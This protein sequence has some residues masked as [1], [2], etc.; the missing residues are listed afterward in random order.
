MKHLFLTFFACMALTA[1]AAPD[2][3]FHIYL[4]FGQSNMEGNARPEAQDY[5]GVS[6]RFQ[7]L[8]AVDFPKYGTKQGEWRTA[9]PPLARPETGLTPVDYFGRT[10]VANTPDDVRIG[11]VVV[12]VGGCKIALFDKRGCRDYVKREAPDWMQGP[13]RAYG[14]NPY[15]RLLTLARQA[16]Q[17]GVIK[18][19]LLHQGESNNTDPQWPVAVKRVYTTLLKDLGLRAEQVPLIAGE[20]VNA[21]HGGTCAAH[22]AQ[23]ARLPQVIPT[24]HTVSSAQLPC[25]F[26]RLHFSALGYRILGERY[27][28]QVLALEGKD[29]AAIKS[30]VNI[31]AENNL[32]GQAFPAVTPDRRA[33]FRFPAPE[34]KSVV[35]DICGK[36]YPLTKGQDGVFRGQTDPLVVGFH[37]YFLVVDG[38]RVSDP[39]T[40]TYFG[41]SRAASGIDIPEGSEGDYYRVHDVPHG[42]VRQCQYYSATTHRTRTIYVYTPAEYEANLSARYPVLVLQH[43]MAEDQTGWSNQGHMQNIMDNLIAA[44]K[45]RPMIVVMESG[46]IEVAH[47]KSRQPIDTYGAELTPVICHDLLPYIDRTFRTVPDRDHRAMAGLSWGGHQTF[48]TV[49]PNLDTF[50]YLGTFSGAIFGVNLK[51]VFGGAFTRP[52]EL[53]ARLHYFFMGSGSE[54]N[55]GTKK[56]VDDLK[57]MGVSVDYY[58]S[59]GTHHE[60]LTWRRCLREFVT[61]IF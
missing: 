10:M 32:A 38:V 42:Q 3:N 31:P 41:C 8:S 4:C 5:E 33:V 39:S 25:A 49:M 44:G 43:G 56:M 45:A 28:K 61:K 1:S 17:Q 47:D 18:G 37:Y 40:H 35:V 57:A 22:N 60:W 15:E 27:A 54:E 11:V 58:E 7:V 50:S 48:Y 14:G 53:N 19:V 29:T 12:A 55:F 21:D 2:P 36:Q 20:T 9:V 30:I 52:D 23:I 59:P 46:D 6:Q 34:A 24:A 16:Q 51:E 26:D 13:I